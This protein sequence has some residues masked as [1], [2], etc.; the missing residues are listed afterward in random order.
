MKLHTLRLFPGSDLKHSLDL[1]VVENNI[2]AAAIITCVGSL[3]IA[4]IRFAGKDLIDTIP[5]PLEILSLVGTFSRSGSHFHISVADNEGK[6]T[7]GH[8][9]EGSIIRTTAEIVIIEAE[10]VIYLREEDP[11]TGFKELKI[12]NK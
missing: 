1:F 11:V 12:K 7:G 10:D 8:L 2:D 4:A 9:K 3:T 6:C 5:G